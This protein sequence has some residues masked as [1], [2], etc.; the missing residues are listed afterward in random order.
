MGDSLPAS[1]FINTIVGYGVISGIFFAIR[2]GGHKGV[3]H[4]DKQKNLT[5]HII[6]SE[7]MI[8]K[9]QRNI[10]EITHT[11]QYNEILFLPEKYRSVQATGYMLECL[12]NLR[13]DSLKEAINL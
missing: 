7:S 8:A 5:E 11:E 13:A 6:K 4:K 9:A 10:L 12:N 1:I 3:S 2:K